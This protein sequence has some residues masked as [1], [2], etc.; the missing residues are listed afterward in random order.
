LVN[1]IAETEGKFNKPTNQAFFKRDVQLPLT[2]SKIKN[3]CER[4]PRILLADASRSIH[5]HGMLSHMIEHLT[6]KD[7]GLMEIR[8]ALQYAIGRLWFNTLWFNTCGWIH[9]RLD[10][11]LD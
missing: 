1:A 6:A 4:I 8:S 2:L 11:M 9:L 5:K 10:V 7:H 3:E